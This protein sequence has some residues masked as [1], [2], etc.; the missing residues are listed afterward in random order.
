MGRIFYI[1]GKSATGKDHIYEKLLTDRRLSGLRIKPLV[2]YT[3]RP[4]RA[5]EEDGVTYHFT[6]EAVLRSLETQGKLIEKRC[7]ETVQGPWYYFTADDGRIDPKTEHYLAIGTPAAYEK[8]RRYYGPEYVTALYVETEDGLRL[9][10]AL[11]RERKQAVPQ[12]EEMCRRFLADQK[13]F[14]PEKL[15]SAGIGRVFT[16]NLDMEQCVDE[17]VAYMLGKYQ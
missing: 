3:T 8:I 11:K 4:M 17:I 5:G 1:M 12:Y 13:D 16:N 15:K 9:E 14:A 10:R 7:Y 6:D 2:I